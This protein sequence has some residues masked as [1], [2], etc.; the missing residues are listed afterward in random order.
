MHSVLTMLDSA[1]EKFGTKTYVS[2]KEGNSWKDYSFLKVRELSTYV[3]S[4]LLSNNIE[5]EDNIVILSEGRSK[6]VIAELGIISA[7]AVSVPLSIK[8]QRS[9]LCVAP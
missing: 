5:K 4:F 6:W 1:A 7:A 8:L 3:G 9:F 2:N